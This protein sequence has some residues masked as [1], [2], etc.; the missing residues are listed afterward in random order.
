MLLQLGTVPTLV[1]STADALREVFKSYDVTFS[2]RPSLSAARRLSYGFVSISFAPYGDYWRQARKLCILEILSAKRV[3][4]FH[5]IREEE[6]AKLVANVTEACSSSNPLN[7]KEVLH[8]SINNIVTRVMFGDRIVARGYG[9]ILEETQRL[10]GEFWVADYL[11]WLGW[12]DAFTGLRRRLEENFKELDWFYDCV[13]KEHM[14][15]TGAHDKEFSDLVDVLLQLH[16]DPVHGMTFS[17]TNH[18]KGIITVSLFN[19][20]NNK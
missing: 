2:N 17:S 18:I 4:S 9:K 19:E 7:L 6:V 15:D 12:I 16:K 5:K 13:I 1:I 10:L 14:S 20:H 11:P 3:Q 8:A